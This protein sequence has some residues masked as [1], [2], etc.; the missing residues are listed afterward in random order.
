MGKLADIRDR[1]MGKDI[2]LTNG[3]DTL[4]ICDNQSLQAVRTE[5]PRT[6]ANHIPGCLD[7]RGKESGGLML[8]RKSDA[9][10]DLPAEKAIT[11][12]Q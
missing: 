2:P 12:M 10:C 8:V 6:L 3:A 4:T 7:W 5:L 9:V 11:A 1:Q